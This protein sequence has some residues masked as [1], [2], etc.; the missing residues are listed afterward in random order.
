MGL[1]LARRLRRSSR[2][3][4]DVGWGHV[5]LA[6]FGQGEAVAASFVPSSAAANSSGGSLRPNGDGEGIAYTKW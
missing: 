2:S 6:W 5:R 3:R 4:Y 1:G